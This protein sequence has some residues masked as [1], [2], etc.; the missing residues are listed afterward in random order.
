MTNYELFHSLFSND[1]T[2]T[3]KYMKS[4]YCYTDDCY[5]DMSKYEKNEQLKHRLYMQDESFDKW[6]KAVIENEFFSENSYRKLDEGRY[7]Y[8]NATLYSSSRMAI[9]LFSKKGNVTKLLNELKLP[10]DYESIELE[11]RY[12]CGV[13]YAKSNIDVSIFLKNSKSVVAVE[14]KM[15][16]IFKR[17][18][19]DFS[20]SYKEKLKEL[21]IGF[22]EYK[23]KNILRVNMLQNTCFDYKQQICH[24]LGLAKYATENKCKVYFLNLVFNPEPLIHH[25]P[26]CQSLSQCYQNYKKEEK[27][28]WELLQNK[29]GFNNNFVFCGQ[30][31]QTFKKE[32]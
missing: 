18:P 30:F 17:W 26:N 1:N 25:I 27:I 8:N 11:H 4:I 28:F 32:Q 21:D 15:Q 7:E 23:D 3:I 6:K 24:Y 31:D 2:D 19:T 20:P 13:P 10:T 14:C 9:E 22:K 29:K 16:E 5:F 12:P